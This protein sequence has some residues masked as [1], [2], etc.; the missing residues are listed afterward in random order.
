MPRTPSP[1]DMAE[2]L[3][4]PTLPAPLIYREHPGDLRFR[5]R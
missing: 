1:V 2:A 5:E 4:F 3:A